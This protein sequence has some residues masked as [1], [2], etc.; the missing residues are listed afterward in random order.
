MKFTPAEAYDLLAHSELVLERLSAATPIVQ[1]PGMEAEQRWLDEAAKRVDLAREGIAVVMERAVRLPELESLR[2]EQAAVLQ[3]AWVDV[4][5]RLLAGI[6]FHAGSR[7]PVIEAL[8]P[9]KVKLPALRRARREIS[10]KFAAELD[11]RLNGAYVTRIFAQP[12]FE[13]AA[14][15]VAQIKEARER[16]LACF[17]LEPLCDEESRA[18]RLELTAAA[19]R[20]DGPMRQA[21]LLAEAALIPVVGAFEESGLGAKPKRRAARAT[22]PEGELPFS[23]GL[24]FAPVPEPVSEPVPEEV[25]E[26]AKELEVEYDP[27]ARAEPAVPEKPKGRRK[28]AAAAVEPGVTARELFNSGKKRGRGAG[29]EAQNGDATGPS[30]EVAA[31]GHTDSIE[32]VASNINAAPETAAEGAAGGKAK[33][34]RK[35]RG[36][37]RASTA[38]AD[39]QTTSDGGAAAPAPGEGADSGDAAVAL[40]EATEA[41]LGEPASEEPAVSSESPPPSD[42][43]GGSGPT[44]SPS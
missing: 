8:I 36:G 26:A 13:F 37:A 40:L 4:V 12:G 42:D 11:R 17:S 38:P 5:E 25:L 9:P 28:T 31:A 16:W 43:E 23:D 29:S 30:V 3:E 19:R 6:T 14:A 7:A 10:E 32:A 34:P 41:R 27:D 1:R 24:E 15:V 18:L 35:K 21:R 22:T 39:G 2:E 44:V 33:K 20:L